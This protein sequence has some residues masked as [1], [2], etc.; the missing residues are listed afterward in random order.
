MRCRP[1][2]TLVVTTASVSILVLAA[3]PVLAAPTPVFSTP[4]AIPADC[5]RDV[6]VDLLAWI[7]S[8][9]DS[10][11]LQFP[12]HGCYRVDGKLTIKNRSGLTFEG[13]DSTFR[14]FT[15]GRELPPTEARARSMW[16]FWHGSNLVV[17]NTIVV[18][19]NP[20]AGTGDTAYV[21]ALEAQSAYVIGGVQGMLLDHVQAYD[22]F[23][24]FVF[25]GPAT[26]D[27]TVQNSTFAR[28]GRQ[29][30]TI[31]G[32]N[33]VFDHN[34]IGYTRRATVD[35][36]PP[37]PWAGSHHVVISNNT[38][39]HG[40]LFFFASEGQAAPIDDVSIVGNHFVGKALTIHV[41]GKPT[42]RRT[43]YRV[44]GNVSDTPAGFGPG[45]VFQ[46]TNVDGIEVRD[47]VQAVQRNR[48][49]KGVS[50]KNCSRVT[51]TG[52]RWLNAFGPIYDKGGNTNVTQSGNWVGRPLVLAPA[53]TV[54]GP[55]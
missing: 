35:M 47:N 52:N 26:R 4:A 44:I 32:E 9:P 28:N 1:L 50:L 51:V 46:F 20:N 8:V 31:N 14:A 36:E 30:W 29:G 11:T 27:L 6:T 49:T 2:L 10:S 19:A 22:V 42:V 40:R 45:G 24:D 7:A 3:S 55:T 43:N 39:T 48:G 21:A 18:G 33:I 25:V 41:W 17:R 5:S 12:S 37:S 34:W 38:V 13:N 23:G 54:L 53:S 16:T 15:N